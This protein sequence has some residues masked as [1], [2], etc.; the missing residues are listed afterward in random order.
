[1]DRRIVLVTMC[2][3]LFLVQLDVTIVNVALPTLQTQMHAQ[4]SDLQWTVDG[5]AIALASLLL[6]GG[7]LG[8]L[9]GHK[10]VVMVG[11][12]VFGAGSLLAGL[13]GSVGLLVAGRVAQGVGAALLLPGTLAVIT[14]AFPQRAERARAIGAWAAISGLSLP[15]GL[16]VGGLLVD[17]LG[18]RSIFLVNLPIVAAALFVTAR[19]VGEGRASG[20]RIDYAGTVLAAGALAA[21]T[22]AFVQS[23]VAAGAVA[24]VLAVAFV[25]VERAQRSPMLPLALFRSGGFSGANAIAAAMNL[26]TL[27]NVF[28]LTLYLQGVRGYSPLEAGLAATPAF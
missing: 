22:F 14:R 20:G 1:M 27:G 8:D 6:A 24:A 18:W 4:V 26:G 17:T 13:A 28:V 15:A 5:Y 21:L 3:G 9:H 2:V 23:S 11:L 10:R 12:V 7:T 19:V 16:L 25:L